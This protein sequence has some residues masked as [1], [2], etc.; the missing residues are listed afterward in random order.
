MPKVILDAGHGGSDIGEYYERR[1][2]KNDN[3]LLALRIGEFLTEHGVD[4]VYTRTSDVYL[5][6]MQRVALANQLGGDLLVSIHRLSGNSSNASPNLDFFLN[7]NDQLG[8][9][10]AN[11]IGENL[12]DYGYE[13]Y[14]V[15][16]R[17]DIPL[18]SDTNMPTIM[19]GIGYVRSQN[20][21]VN[22]DNNFVNIA[23][24]IAKGIYQSLLDNETEVSVSSFRE[25]TYYYR[26]GLGPYSNYWEAIDKQ[27]VLCNLGYDTEIVKIMLS[28]YIYTDCLEDLD[29]A[30]VIELRFR[31]CGFHSFIIRA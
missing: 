5:P 21:N 8:E 19:V 14:G 30:S 13:N 11:N 7:E 20:D 9:R 1:S 31:R 3:L 29:E 17:T 6:M 15:I 22:Y 4:V 25:S 12:Y 16:V 10:A 28:Y 26:I 2:E 23:H 18:I 27:L 24:G